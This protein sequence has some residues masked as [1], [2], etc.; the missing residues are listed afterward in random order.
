MKIISILRIIGFIGTILTSIPLFISYI[1][2]HDPGNPLIVHLHVWLGVLFIVFAVTNM[3]MNKRA[4][5]Q[6]S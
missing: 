6:K 3:I 2:N 4:E 1:S 5:K